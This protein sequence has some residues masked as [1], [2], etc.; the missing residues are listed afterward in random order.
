[1]KTQKIM[2]LVNKLSNEEYKFDT[3]KWYVIES[4]IAK[5]KYNQ[6]K[7]TKFETENIKSSLCDYSVAFILVTQNTTVN[8]R[9]NTDIAFKIC[10]PFSACKTEIYDV[11][12][13]EANHLYIATL[14]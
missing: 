2:N 12:I 6:N 3:K 8:A 10:A 1:M 13:D 14:L 9:N 7:S 4:Q 5:G 11:F